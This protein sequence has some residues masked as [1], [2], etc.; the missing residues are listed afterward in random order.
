MIV[1]AN[2]KLYKVSA[3]LRVGCAQVANLASYSGLSGG[4]Q[5][6]SNS[7]LVSRSSIIDGLSNFGRHTN[8]M[9]VHREVLSIGGPGQT[10]STCETML[11]GPS[12]TGIT[13]P[14][15][16]LANECPGRVA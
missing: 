2:L 15:Y 10:L 5:W 9:L 7:T 14:C 8:H 3:R 13:G 11:P 6:L 16:I 12:F 4:L 1:Y